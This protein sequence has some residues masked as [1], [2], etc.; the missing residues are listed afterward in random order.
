MT[1]A[2]E[3]NCRPAEPGIADVVTPEVADDDV[4]GLLWDLTDEQRERISE[5][6]VAGLR[7][8]RR[9]AAT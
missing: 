5:Y 1:R 7:G 3:A 4:R 2:E 8:V 9:S 6:I